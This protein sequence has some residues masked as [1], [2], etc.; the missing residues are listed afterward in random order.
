MEEED[1]GNRDHNFKGK[2]QGHSDQ[3][4]LARRIT[5]FL[6]HAFVAKSK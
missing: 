6:H 3:K 1:F 4:T 2:W 5:P